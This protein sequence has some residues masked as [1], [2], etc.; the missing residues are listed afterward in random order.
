MPYLKEKIEGDLRETFKFMTQERLSCEAKLLL[1]HYQRKMGQLLIQ[2]S[3]KIL[4]KDQKFEMENL[5]DRSV[6]EGE[7]KGLEK[8]EKQK[9]KRILED[10]KTK[11]KRQ[12]AEEKVLRQINQSN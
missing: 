11:S 3:D 2:K 9:I 10:R 8:T 7:E 12:K 5:E 1:R 4:E 6:Q